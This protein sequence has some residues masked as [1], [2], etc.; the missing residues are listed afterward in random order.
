[1]LAGSLRRINLAIALG[2]GALLLLTALFVIADVVLRQLGASLGGSDELTGYV[3]AATASWGLSYALIELAHVRIDILRLALKPPGRAIMD[4]LAI[5]VLAVATI[6]IAAQC[7]PVLEK[8]IMRGSRANTPLETPL[9]IPQAIW[10]SGWVW[11]A[12]TASVLV[13]CAL[14]SLYRRDLSR[15]NALVG[16][17]T[18]DRE[19]E[20]P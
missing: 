14:A 13:M 10:F 2:V 1:M 20:A 15:L 17:Q 4:V 8:S 16:T 11:F 12:L 19:G 9:W 5:L 3:M 7:W 18:E 6:V